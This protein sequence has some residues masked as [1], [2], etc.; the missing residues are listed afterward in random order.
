L[1][2]LE[3]NALLDATKTRKYRTLFRFA[4][5]SGARQGEL[6]G[7]KWT[8]VDWFNNQIH[9]QR[10]FNSGAWYK[11]KSK[12]SNRKIDIGPAMMTELKKW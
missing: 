4:I 2:P 3:I 8:D 5:F 6:L 12:N 9:V 7:L 11:P 10:T 1:T